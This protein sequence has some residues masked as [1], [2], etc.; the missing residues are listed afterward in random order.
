MKY[1]N[2]YYVYKHINAETNI[3]FYVGKGINDRAYSKA[4]RNILWKNIVNK[5][6]YRVEFIMTNLNELE[7]YYLENFYIKLYKRKSDG[8]LLVNLTDG[9]DGQSGAVWTEDRRKLM[10]KKI[11][12]K[13]LKPV[14]VDK[15]ISDYKTIWNLSDVA[16]LHGICEGTAKKYIPK[17]LRIQSRS[18]NGQMNSIRLLNKK[19][20]NYG[21]KIGNKCIRKKSG[22]LPIWQKDNN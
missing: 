2:N 7:A 11:T 9:G 12:G 4:S 19:P 22:Q 15:L 1:S 8:G 3:P 13:I 10:S 18:K 6:G 17:E 5:Y 21:K 20:W 16:K 14:D